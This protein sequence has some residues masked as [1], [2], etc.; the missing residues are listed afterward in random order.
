MR[1]ISAFWYSSDVQT[2][3]MWYTLSAAKQDILRQDVMSTCMLMCVLSVQ[4]AITDDR[5]PTADTML[6]MYE[7]SMYSCKHDSRC[8]SIKAIHQPLPRPLQE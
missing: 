5:Q 4:F 6:L 8:C 3:M 7:Q 1:T 2:Q